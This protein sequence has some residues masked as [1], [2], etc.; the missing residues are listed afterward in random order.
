MV[1]IY[2]KVFSLIYLVVTILHLIYNTSETKTAWWQS[3]GQK[4]CR[5]CIASS[6][7]QTKT[8]KLKSCS[9]VQKEMYC[10]PSSLGQKGHSIQKLYKIW[11][12]RFLKNVILQYNTIQLNITKK[13]TFAV[14]MSQIFTSYDVHVKITWSKV[15]VFIVFL[16]KLHTNL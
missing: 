9:H 6:K 3:C 14:F 10:K 12:I 4:F 15:L 1:G 13:K 11:M 8:F 2:S 5:K 16:T 7:T